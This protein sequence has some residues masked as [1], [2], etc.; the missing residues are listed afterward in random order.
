MGTNRM[1]WYV[2]YLVGISG[3]HFRSLFDERS[4]ISIKQANLSDNENAYG[5]GELKNSDLPTHADLSS[6][7]ATLV[8]LPTIKYAWL[9]PP[10]QDTKAVVAIERWEK[11]LL[12]LLPDSSIIRFDEILLED[13]LRGRDDENWFHSEER[14]RQFLDWLMAQEQAH[15]K[16]IR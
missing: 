12:D 13:W 4:R 2:H 9:V 11:N 8:A 16:Q 5:E 7:I 6:T 1:G 15:W 10:V 14:V 3:K